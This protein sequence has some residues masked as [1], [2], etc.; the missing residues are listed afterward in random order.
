M[1]RE[2]ATGFIQEL[3][4]LLVKQ[5]GSDLFITAVGGNR[6]FHNEPNPYEISGEEPSHDACPNAVH[7]CLFHEYVSLALDRLQILWSD[8]ARFQKPSFQ[9]DGLVR[10]GVMESD[11]EFIIFSKVFQGL[12][13]GG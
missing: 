9:L 2:R 13:S 12:R 7:F 3:L 5:K 4:T 6:L 11:G 10:R 8:F 1:E